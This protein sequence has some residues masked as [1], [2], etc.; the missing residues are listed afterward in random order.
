M[1][2]S[3]LTLAERPIM[4]VMIPRREIEK[5]DISQSREE[6]NAQLKNTP[7]SRLLVVGKAGVDEP[8]GYIS[9]KRF[10]EPAA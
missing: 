6:Q 1:I 4:G 3:V 5:L 9:K 7:Y 8:L 10:A 2:R